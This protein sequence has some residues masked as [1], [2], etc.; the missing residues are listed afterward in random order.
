MDTIQ[1]L[2]AKLQYKRDLVNLTASVEK[3]KRIKNDIK[4]ILMKIEIE[5][6]KEKTEKLR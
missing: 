6:I 3:Q 1:K 5:R 4:I 2:N